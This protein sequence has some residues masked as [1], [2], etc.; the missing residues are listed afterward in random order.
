MEY[1]A[2]F[3][4]ITLILTGLGIWAMLGYYPGKIARTR[5]HPQAEAISVCGWVGAL[6]L[7]V[8]SPL[9]FIWAYTH[10]TH[11]LTGRPI[12]DGGEDALS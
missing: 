6:T 12:G 5:R 2:L 3:I 1:F 11:T 4:L 8:L 7:G 9:A 10:P